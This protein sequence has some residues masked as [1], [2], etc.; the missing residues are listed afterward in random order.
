[1]LSG[2]K[3]L[4]FKAGSS[5]GQ[6]SLL[7]FYFFVK[8]TDRNSMGGTKENSPYRNPQK[9]YICPLFLPGTETCVSVQ[10]YW[11]SMKDRRAA[12]VWVYNSLVTSVLHPVS[13]GAPQSHEV[14]YHKPPVISGYGNISQALHTDNGFI[15]SQPGNFSLKGSLKLVSAGKSAAL[16]SPF[17][18]H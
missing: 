9:K 2:C 6:Y 16:L 18:P 5:G 17:I 12:T 3:S 14:V 7:L 11:L 1:M 15:M 4:G 8:S 10:S 13:R